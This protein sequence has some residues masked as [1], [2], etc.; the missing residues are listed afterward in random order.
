MK[1]TKHIPFYYLE[2]RIPYINRILEETAKYPATLVDVFI[3][4][5]LA[6]L[7]STDFK[8]RGTKGCDIHIYIVYHDLT[9]ENPFYLTW[10]CRPLMAQQRFEYDVFMYLEDDILVPKEAIEYWITYN[11]I[12]VPLGYNLGFL[13]VECDPQISGGCEYITDLYGVR[14]D[15]FI[16]LES[17]TFCINNKNAYC[18]FWIYDREEFGRFVES[19]L[20]WFYNPDGYDIR[21]LS[22]AGL[23]G[24]Q[25]GWYKDTVIPLDLDK[26]GLDKGCRIYH[27]SNNYIT[28]NKSPFA[29][30][31]FDDAI[32]SVTKSYTTISRNIT[33]DNPKNNKSNNDNPNIIYIVSSLT[34]EF[35]RNNKVRRTVK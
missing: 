6:T 26:Q 24:H 17:K 34:D 9:G 4:T 1:I 3:H 27:M 11:P 12:L 7:K 30:I 33:N 25:M 16:N 31:P 8:Y 23:H 10:K 35:N 19:D 21:E 13:R 15:S 29:T 20:Y 22:G 14:F 18:A 5:N 32:S 28:N 2:N